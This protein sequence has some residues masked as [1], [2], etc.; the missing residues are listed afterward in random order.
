MINR[1]KSE[2]LRDVLILMSGTTIA[3]IIPISI[4]PILTRLYTPEDFGV[5]ALFVAIVGL[6]AVTASAG[7][8]QAILIPNYDKYAINIL[9]LGFFLVCFTVIF[10]YLLIFL[11]KENI[12]NLLNSSLLGDWLYIAPVTVF[13]VGLFN[14]LRNYNIRKKHYKDI[15]KAMVIKSTVLAIIQITIGILKSGFTGL[16]L[17]QVFAQL[18]ANIKLMTNI[19]KNKALLSSISLNKVFAVARKYKNFPKYN[20]PHSLLNTLSASLPI[21]IFTSFFGSTVAG[22]YS[23]ALIAV[24]VPM[25]IVASST[26]HV[27]SQKATELYNGGEN[28]YSFTIK[29]IKLLIKIFFIPYCIFIFFAPHIFKFIFSKEWTDVGIYIQILSVYIFLNFIVSIIS[30]IPMI[31]KLQKKAVTISII[32]FII[33]FISLYFTAKTYDVFMALGVM[34]LVNSVILIYR[35]FWM[36][37]SIKK[38]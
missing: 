37:N 38:L 8:E 13:F 10:A 30:Y 17:G 29:I 20:M 1:L 19:V 25:A 24:F 27:Y 32:H 15:A 35:F 36:I 34:C 16:I 3:Q 23:L 33:L 5:F 11:F 6:M 28:I 18:F 22:Y 14:L 4:S 21:Y 26:A 7:Y 9:V 12:L 2:F 31:K